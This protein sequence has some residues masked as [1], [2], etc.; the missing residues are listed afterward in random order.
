MRSAQSDIISRGLRFKENQAECLKMLID[1]LWH[2]KCQLVENQANGKEKL[3]KR[4]TQL[5]M[6]RKSEVDEYVVDC[7]RR[8]SSF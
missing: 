2:W 7:S 8:F 6:L 5:T 3:G 4:D 1:K